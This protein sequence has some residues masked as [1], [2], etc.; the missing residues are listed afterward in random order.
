MTKEQDGYK[1]R[2]RYMTELEKAFELSVSP[3]FLQ[4]DRRAAKPTIPFRKFGRLIRYPI[5]ED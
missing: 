4:K 5:D 2:R 3:S 1:P